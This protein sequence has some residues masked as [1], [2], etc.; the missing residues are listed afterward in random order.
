MLPPSVPSR[1]STEATVTMA[2][3]PGLEHRAEG[4]LAGQERALE[5]DV[6]DPVPLV[7]VDQVDRPAAGDA[8]GGDHGVEPAVG[9]DGGADGGGQPGLVPH[10]DLVPGRGRLTLGRRAEVEADDRRP[11]VHEAVDARRPDP[12]CRA[13]D[14]RDPSVQSSHG[15]T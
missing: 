11:L 10:V 4:V 3:G 12:R 2:P 9:L 14:Q 1:P 6:L 5:V 7:G 8:R 13:G 15:G